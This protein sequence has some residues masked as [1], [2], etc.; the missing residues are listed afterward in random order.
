MEQ[1]HFTTRVLGPIA[2]YR[3]EQ[4]KVTQ[5]LRSYTSS[6]AQAALTGQLK[7]GD[8]MEV[9]LDNRLL[10]HAVFV[11]M[12][13]LSWVDIDTANAHR[14]GFDDLADLEKALQRAGYRFR[15]INMYRLYRIQFSWLEEV[16][17]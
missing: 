17:A 12:D 15:P 3:L 8:Q 9:L 10:G 4:R 2:A 6:A 16:L 7:V 1:L 13:A 5:T 11:I 14:G